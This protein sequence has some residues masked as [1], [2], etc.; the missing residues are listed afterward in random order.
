MIPKIIH[1][2]WLSGEAKPESIQR[3]LDSWK[4][5]LP[6]FEIREW[7]MK[8]VENIDST[9]LKGAIRARKWA[10]A[11]D[12]LRFNIIYE[13]GG[14]YLDSDVYVLRDLSPLMDCAG[15]TALEGSGILFPEQYGKIQDFGLEAAAFGAE[16]HSPWIKSILD[17]YSDLEF[18]DS[19]EFMHRIIAPKVMWARS[20]RIGLRRVPS[21]QQLEGDVRIYPLD[22]ISC[23]ADWSLYAT[24][25]GDVEKVM[26]LNPC[27]YAVHMC[28]N[29]WGW[30]P[31]PT[32]K[33]KVKEFLI[34]VL[35]ADTAVKMKRAV[36]KAFGS[37]R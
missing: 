7:T 13:I 32:M 15:F 27:R 37:S 24:V 33:M 8:D 20:E 21:F 23:I 31:R 2:V 11:T 9:F 4:R 12:F 1:Y 14:V 5:N 34:R 18:H 6:G 10:F 35:G 36:K 19:Q 28:A 22:T 30:K 29:S 26:A 17:F 3:C 25:P 16:P